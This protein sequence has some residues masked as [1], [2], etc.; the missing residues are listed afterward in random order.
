MP[1]ATRPTGAPAQIAP[2]ASGCLDGLRAL[3]APLEEATRGGLV[4]GIVQRFVEHFDARVERRWIAVRDGERLGSVFVVRRSRTV[5]RLRL[6]VA[7]HSAL[8][9]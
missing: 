4:A 3:F 7:E 6:Q 2:D 1:P 5:A 9:L 8:R